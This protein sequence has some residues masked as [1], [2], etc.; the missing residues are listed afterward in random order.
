MKQYNFTWLAGCLIGM[1]LVSI[2]SGSRCA[3]QDLN[4]EVF[5]ARIKTFA[6]VGSS[7]SKKIIAQW[8]AQ[9]L[10]NKALTSKLLFEWGA[11]G[12][13]VGS[14]YDLLLDNSMLLNRILDLKEALEEA[15]EKVWQ[16]IVA[17]EKTR[18][19]VVKL[20]IDS[21]MQQRSLYSGEEQQLLFNIGKAGAPGNTVTLFTWLDKKNISLSRQEIYQTM[22]DAYQAMEDA[23]ADLDNPAE[24]AKLYKKAINGMREAQ[25][26]AAK[27]GQRQFEALAKALEDLFETWSKR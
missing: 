20:S 17:E 10:A 27:S 9:P 7:K 5:T 6:P 22:Q 23:L 18:R 3:E 1:L 12:A 26:Q 4:V 24:R 14:R 16:E 15:I 19:A 21:M 2:P 11:P 25:K 13:S 8:Q